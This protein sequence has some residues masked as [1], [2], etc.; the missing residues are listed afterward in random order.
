MRVWVRD[1]A[2]MINGTI[3]RGPQ[4]S[5]EPLVVLTACSGQTVKH[6]NTVIFPN[7]QAFQ[8]SWEEPVNVVNIGMSKYM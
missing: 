3:L 7:I 5:Q 4:T 1:A 2:K 6:T 8:I